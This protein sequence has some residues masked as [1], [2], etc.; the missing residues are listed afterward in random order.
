[1]SKGI[2]FSITQTFIT[3]IAIGFLVILIGL[4]LGKYFETHSMIESSEVEHHSILLGNLYLSSDML[5]VTDGNNIQRA[6]FDKNKLDKQLINKWNFGDYLKLIKGNELFK[7][8]SYPA[9]IILMTV[10]DSESGNG[11][12]MIGGGA[13][14]SDA[15]KNL[16]GDFSGCLMRNIKIDWNTPFRRMYGNIYFPSLWDQQ[17]FDACLKAAGTKSGVAYKEFPISI[18][19]GSSVHVGWM[20]IVLAE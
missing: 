14:K 9:S 1:M 11:W 12:F 16:V 10:G 3:L 5:S 7:E 19:D 8:L 13:A 20:L 6:I 18:K 2:A 4:V 17:D 15:G